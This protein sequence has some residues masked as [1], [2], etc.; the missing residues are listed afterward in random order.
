MMPTDQAMDMV[1]AACD[2]I[3]KRFLSDRLPPSFS[4]DEFAYTSEGQK[5]SQIWSSTWCRLAR[6]GIARLVLEDGKAVVYHCNDNSRVYQ[7]VPLSPMEF[8]VDDGPALEQ[9]ITTVEPF[10][11]PVSDLIHESIEDKIGIAQAL[12]SEGIL[13]IVNP[14]GDPARSKSAS[15]E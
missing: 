14:N 10:W 1:D 4:P 3:G 13:A 2:Q 9:L 12:Y 8:E 11:I 7:E 6:P 15:V 5:D